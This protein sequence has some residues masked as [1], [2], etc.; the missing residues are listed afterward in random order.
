MEE[1]TMAK[2]LKL[3]RVRS[4]ETIYSLAD[5]LGVNYSTVSYW[6]N[7]KRYPR[8]DRIIQLCKMFKKEYTDLM[9]DMSSE[10]E[11][12]VSRKKVKKMTPS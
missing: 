10:E 1:Y 11:L 7:G 8:H 9:E 4:G 2:K 5:K 3:Y 12:E 6:E